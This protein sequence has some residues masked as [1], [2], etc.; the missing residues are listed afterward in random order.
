M[1]SCRV[2]SF[3]GRRDSNYHIWSF[4]YFG[5]KNQW[6]KNIS[7]KSKK[8]ASENFLHFKKTKKNE[9]KDDKNIIKI[10]IEKSN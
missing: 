5:K 1:A 9:K 8:K 10:E 3:I 2:F 4:N 7:V 6:N